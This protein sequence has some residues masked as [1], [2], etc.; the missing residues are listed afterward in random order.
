MFDCCICHQHAR[1]TLTGVLRHIKEVHP[2]FTSSV[3]CG[4]DG[5]MSTPK[6]FQAL[7]RHIYRYHKNL[8]SI[9]SNTA[10][11][12]GGETATNNND[13]TDLLVND[14][15]DGNSLDEEDFQHQLVME[16]D[17]T[18]L[19]GAHFILK[20]RDGKKLT[21]TTTNEIIC[22]TV[23]AISNVSETL[24]CNLFKKIDEIGVVMTDDQRAELAS[25]FSNPEVINPFLGLETE[26]KQEKFIKEHFHYVVKL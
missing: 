13:D 18:K 7:R 4:L 21:Q 25:V 14:R 8:L 19:V 24:Q 26:Y 1:R 9:R 6:S 12:I 22:D 3:I 17:T 16:N 2:H 20:T 23:T 10:A 11:S 15:L 5:C